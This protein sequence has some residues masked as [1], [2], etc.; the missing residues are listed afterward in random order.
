LI[1]RN[2]TPFSQDGRRPYVD[3]KNYVLVS[4]FGLYHYSGQGAE[5]KLLG[6]KKPLTDCMQTV[7]G[8]NNSIITLVNDHMLS[9]VI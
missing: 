9:I 3:K 4:K 5:Q 7:A 8:I 2:I 1:G 6:Q